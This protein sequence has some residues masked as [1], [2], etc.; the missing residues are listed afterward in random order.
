VNTC[1]ICRARHHRILL[2]GPHP[3]VLEPIR[4]VLVASGRYDVRTVATLDAALSAA[5]MQQPDLAL[6]D[7][8]FAPS[9][10]VA[11]G[12]LLAVLPQLKI[13][14]LADDFSSEAVGAA[15]DAGVAGCISKAI[16]CSGL[17]GSMDDVLHIGAVLDPASAAA[18]V[19]HHAVTNIAEEI[20]PR[21]RQVL[22]LVASGFAN[23]DIA[24]E[25][26]I[27]DRTVKAHLTKVFHRIGAVNRTEAALWAR[28]SGL[29]DDRP[30]K[31][32]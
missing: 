14:V 18:L 1:D 19:R 32:S 21:E 16:A 28:R 22:V 17:V 27:T 3:I 31:V 13:V 29:F 23:K 15:V 5:E 4:S 7:Q 10:A 24:R 20:S 9:I 8:A 26:G 30:Q 11:V 25:M 6:V 2:A 12:R